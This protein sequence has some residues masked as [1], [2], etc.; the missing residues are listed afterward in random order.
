MH[1]GGMLS[2]V[3][4]LALS[5][6]AEAQCCNSCIVPQVVVCESHDVPGGAAHAWTMK[7]P[8]GGL[9]HFESGPSLY[10]GAPAALRLTYLPAV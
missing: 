1:K 6:A 3:E 9:Y 7:A 4:W 10:S 8:G 2:R 5:E